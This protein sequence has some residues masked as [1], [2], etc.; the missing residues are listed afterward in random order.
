MKNGFSL[1]CKMDESKGE[2]IF[3][4][5]IRVSYIITEYRYEEITDIELI[6]ILDIK[7]A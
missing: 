3:L 5:L 6:A 7:S 4:N 2:T 1:L